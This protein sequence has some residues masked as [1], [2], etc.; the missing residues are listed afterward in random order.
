MA[1]QYDE[2]AW[3][4]VKATKIVTKYT[5]QLAGQEFRVHE[6]DTNSPALKFESQTQAEAALKVQE[7]LAGAVG[8]SQT[9]ILV[10]VEG[11]AASLQKVQQSYTDSEEAV[12]RDEALLVLQVGLRCIGAHSEN[13][14][15]IAVVAFNKA[16]VARRK[17]I[18]ES[19]SS[20]QKGLKEKMAKLQPGEKL[21]FGG[22][23][24][25]LAKAQRD[26]NAGG[27]NHSSFLFL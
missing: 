20:Q 14:A 2:Q 22:K 23:I 4:A 25:S 13:A 21:L 27:K 10:T 5:G 9:S 15:K 8:V 17:P 18:L 1:E 7:S 6:K 24:D 11:L 19:I 16:I 3:K 12:D 26:I